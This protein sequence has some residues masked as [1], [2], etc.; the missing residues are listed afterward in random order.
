MTVEKVTFTPLRGVHAHKE[1]MG[2]EA[3]DLGVSNLIQQLKP[4]VKLYFSVQWFQY[5]QVS[6]RI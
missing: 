5:P 3:W 4:T 2:H 6:L 1:M